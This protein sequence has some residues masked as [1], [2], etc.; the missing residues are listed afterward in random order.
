MVYRRVIFE[1]ILDKYDKKKKKKK[2]KKSTLVSL[3]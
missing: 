2:K 3:K 1:S